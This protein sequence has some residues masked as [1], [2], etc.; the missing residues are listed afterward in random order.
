MRTVPFSSD[1]FSVPTATLGSDLEAN[2]LVSAVRGFARRWCDDDDT[3][4]SSEPTVKRAPYIAL[5][6]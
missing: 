3:F 1:A 5:T 4:D 6:A 2:R